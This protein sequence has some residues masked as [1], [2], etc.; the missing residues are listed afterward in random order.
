MSS[1]WVAVASSDGIDID[2]R[3]REASCFYI[4]EVKPDG[5]RFVERRTGDLTEYSR[6][7]GSFSARMGR[8]LDNVSDCSLLLVQDLECQCTGKLRFGW[9]TVYEAP[10]SITKALTKLTESLLFRREL[11]WPIHSRVYHA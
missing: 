2:Q 10:M 7:S 9:V 5:F 4:Y 6:D 1:I 3:L 11:Q 8:L